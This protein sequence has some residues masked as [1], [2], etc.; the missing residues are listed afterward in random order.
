M[1]EFDRNGHVKTYQNIQGQPKAKVSGLWHLI[2]LSRPQFKW[3]ASG[4]FFSIIG[5]VFNLL[6][7]KYAGNLINSFTGKNFSHIHLSSSLVT[8][9]LVLF[10]GGA[11]I[12]ALGSFLTGVAGEQLVRNL[13]QIVWDKLVVFKISYYDQVKSGETTSRLTSDTAQVKTL[14]ANAL[15]SFLTNLIAM[16]GAVILM[17]TTDW[18]MA[19]WIFIAVPVTALL[20]TPVFIFGSKVGHATQDAMAEFTGASQETLSEMRLVKSSGAEKFALHRGAQQIQNLFKYGRRE[21]IVDGVMQP[22]MT[23][24]MMG[25]FVLILVVGSLRVAKGESNM[26]TLFSFIMYLFQIMPALVSVGT[27]GSTFAKTQGATQRL[28][29]LLD[30]PVEDLTKGDSINVE[31]QTIV[32]N[33]VDFEYESGKPILK[34]VTF[35][36]KPNTIVAFAGPSGGGKSTIFQLLERFYQPTSGEIKV[37]DYNIDNVSLS[38]WRRQIGF[39]SQDSAIMAGTIRENLTYGLEETY[40]AEQLWHVLHLAYAEQFVSEMPQKLDTQ[41]GERGVKVSGGQ[42]QRLAIARAFLRDPKILMLDEATASLDSESEAM[43]QRALEKLMENR[44][45]LV[46][47]HRLST[48]VDADNIYFIEHGEVTGSGTH[49]ELL[50]SHELY[51]EYV[52]EQIVTD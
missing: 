7:P 4:L 23:M 19:I 6:T 51:A 41:V 28:I 18:H 44:T 48:I 38:S 42:R 37:G 20:V 5:V 22:I 10:V 35:E 13:R 26:G 25:L 36:A 52:H 9:I 50:A 8:L 29:T 40:T 49:Q 16:V 46:I 21:A 15:P 39:V 2:K 30:T 31:G 47:A 27:F 11:I 1:A 45:T 24:V 32:A 17:F 12:S 43:V 34:N 3:M 14:V 33:Q